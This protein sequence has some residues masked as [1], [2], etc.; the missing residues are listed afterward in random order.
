MT[1]RHIQLV[2]SKTCIKYK[3]LC[4]LIKESWTFRRFKLRLHIYTGHFQC[5]MYLLCWQRKARVPGEQYKK[6][7]GNYDI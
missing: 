2:N 3:F 6:L 4:T 1:V 5:S 7:P